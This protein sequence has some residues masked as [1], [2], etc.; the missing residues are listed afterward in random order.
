M[1]F[2]AIVLVASFVQALLMCPRCNGYAEYATVTSFNLVLYVLLWRGNS[3]LAEYLS[4]KTSWVEYPVRRFFI[5]LATTVVYTITVA[6]AVI[7]IYDHYLGLNF[8][9]SY[10]LTIIIVLVSTFVI[11]LFVHSRAFLKSWR[12]AAIEAERLQRESIS[13]RYENLKTQINP[14]FLFQSLDDLDKLIFV[15]E[16]KAVTFIKRLSDVYRYVLD[17]REK[18]VVS[19]QRE[20][21][22]LR[23]YFFLLRERHGNSFAGDMG[24]F[25]TDFYVPPLAIQMIIESNLVNAQFSRES[26]FRI[27]VGEKDGQ[28]I[29]RHPSRFKDKSARDRYQ[30]VIGRIKDRVSFLA[31]APLEVNEADGEIVVIFPVINHVAEEL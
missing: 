19:I 15:D 13:A 20:E 21:R 8:G 16:E 3:F 7:L 10:R 29:V 6:L 4:R 1:I 12:K 14:D 31:L 24:W 18:E 2:L 22:F 27:W 23:D 26:P 30:E 11:S 5:G 28:A 9:S 17:T 25:T